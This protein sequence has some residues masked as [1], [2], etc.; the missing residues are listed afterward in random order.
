MAKTKLYTIALENRP[1]ALA[2]VVRTLANAEVNILAVL[3][4]AQGTG[5]S[6]DLVVEDARGAK[7]A[8]D[9]A[10]IAYRESAAVAYELPNKAG[11]LADCLTK[12]AKRGVNLDSICATASKGAKKAL[13]IC[14]ISAAEEK[15]EPPAFF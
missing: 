6:T 13:A 14:R 10:K 3:G 9:K 11:A 2:D 5:G 7:K 12:L 15:V 8:L 4:T 1:G